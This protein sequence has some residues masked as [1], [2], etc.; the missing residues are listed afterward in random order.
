MSHT[1]TNKRGN[2]NTAAQYVQ[3]A[4]QIIQHVHSQESGLVN[5]GW[6]CKFHLEM[7]LW[8]LAQFARWNHFDLLE[9]SVHSIYERL[10]S[11]GIARARDQGYSGARWGKMTDLTGRSAPGQINALLIWLQLHPMYFAELRFPRA[12]A[13]SHQLLGRLCGLSC[14]ANAC[15]ARHASLAM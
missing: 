4:R 6:Y 7:A 12:V 9:R 13:F 10:V 11:S 2:R 1:T 5:N 14:I 3:S 8:H 15:T